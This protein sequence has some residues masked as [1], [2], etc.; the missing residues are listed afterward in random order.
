[1]LEQKETKVNIGLRKSLL[2]VSCRDLINKVAHTNNVSFSKKQCCK[3]TYHARVV[4]LEHK[5]K[6]GMHRK[7]S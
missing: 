2:S 5:E 4:V 3:I 6:L 7:N 1:M